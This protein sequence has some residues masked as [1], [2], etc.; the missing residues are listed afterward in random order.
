M[1]EHQEPVGL[2]VFRTVLWH[3]G[4]DPFSMGPEDCEFHQ[5]SRVEQYVRIL[6]E[7]IYPPDLRPADV[8]PVGNGLTCS[9]RSLQ[10]ITHYPPQEPVVTGG[11]AVMGIQRDGSDGT[12]E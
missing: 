7:R 1:Q 10:E 3:R 2:A 6:L 9:E 11:Y 4:Q 8:W 5:V 12:Y